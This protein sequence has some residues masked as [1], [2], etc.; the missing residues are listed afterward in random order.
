[1]M[2]KKTGRPKKKRRVT[3][4]VVLDSFTQQQLQLWESHGDT[5]QWLSDRI[6]F[7]LELQRVTHYDALCASLRAAPAVAVELAGWAR[8][9]DWRWNLSPLSAAGSVSGIGGRFNI[10]IELDR[11]KNQAFKSLY[12]AQNLETAFNEFFGGGLSAKTGELS[13]GGELKQTSL[14]SHRI[15]SKSIADKGL[16]EF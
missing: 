11:A 5:F 10:G 16:C 13:I 12:L 2:K 15:S 14:K 1:M 9:T 3:K 8:V 4:G 6:Y 7:D